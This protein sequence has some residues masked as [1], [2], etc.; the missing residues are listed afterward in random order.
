MFDKVYQSLDYW[1]SVMDVVRVGP[2][3]WNLTPNAT[4]PEKHGFGFHFS[5]DCLS[6]DTP[7]RFRRIGEG[8]GYRLTFPE[9]IHDPESHVLVLE[10]ALW[11]RL[12]G[13]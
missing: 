10:A 9:A 12:T 4:W 8:P 2:L 6:S 11:T 1:L 5:R 13:T 7:C 3:D